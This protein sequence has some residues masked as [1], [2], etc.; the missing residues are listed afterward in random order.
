[1]SIHIYRRVSTSDQASDDR[2]SLSDQDRCCRGAAMI[3]G[4][5][6]PQDWCDPGVSVS[7]PLSE[8][9]AGGHML[10]V[11]R[12]GD[13][14]IAAKLDRMFRSASDALATAESFQERGI[15]LV[16]LDCGAEPVTNGAA[17]LF[18]SILAA[19]AEFEKGRTLERMADGRRG[20]RARGGHIGGEAPYGS[21]ILGAGREAILVDEPNE[22]A[23][24]TKARALREEGMSLTAIGRELEREGY[25][26]R[27]GRAWDAQ[28]I[29]RMM[30]QIKTV[31]P[32]APRLGEV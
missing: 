13:T 16:L 23:C 9:A 27:S 31:T 7:T 17:K 12:P 15:H 4:T 24:I 6:A 11:L 28:Q 22:Q 20:K 19:V 1:M 25:W 2:S 30:P 32:V 10:R 14:V 8:R 26:P 5:E 21:R 29:R 3:L 18:F